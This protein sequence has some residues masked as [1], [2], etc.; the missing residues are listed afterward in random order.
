MN[1]PNESWSSRWSAQE[2]ALCALLKEIVG[3]APQLPCER[4]HDASQ[5]RWAESA[6]RQAARYAP[7]LE[8][9]V[10]IP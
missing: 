9:T 3:S 2:G 10:R 8:L 5:G 4:M 6:A 1:A 7:R